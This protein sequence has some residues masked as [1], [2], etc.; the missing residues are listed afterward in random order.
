[1]LFYTLAIF[2]TVSNMWAIPISEEAPAHAR[3]KLV[4]VVY[5]IGLIPLQAILPP[6]LINRLGLDWK[7]MY[8]VMF[9]LMI[10]VLVLWLF[11]RE[12][13]RFKIIQEEQ[14]RGIRKKHWYGLGVIDRKDVRFI[15]LSALIW[16]CWLINSLL[17]YWAGYYFMTVKGYTLAQWSMVLLATLIMAIIGGI[18]GGW[19]MDHTGRKAVLVVGCLGF[20]VVLILMGFTNGMILNIVT[21]L[22]GFFTSLTYSWIVVY[23]PEV[24]PTERRGTCMGWTTTLARISYVVGPALAGILLDA[25]PTMEWFWVVAGLIMLIPVGIVTVFKF[26]ETKTLELEEIE[27]GR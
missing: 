15:I 27:V 17:Y 4:S 20:M 3:A 21:V 24:F 16:L 13:E 2:T 14:K 12:T 7:W 22:S 11:M 25:F 23:I 26:Y 19:M 5:V 10:P 1:M 6:L 8:G 9:I 18:T